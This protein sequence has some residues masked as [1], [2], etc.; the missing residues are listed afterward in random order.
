MAHCN[1]NEFASRLAECLA[2]AKGHPSKRPVVVIGSGCGNFFQQIEHRSTLRKKMPEED[3]DDLNK[4]DFKCWT[5]YENARLCSANVRP[6]EDYYV[7][8]AMTRASLVDVVITSNYDLLLDSMLQRV[9]AG[10]PFHINPI[11]RDPDPKAYNADGCFARSDTEENA[12]RIYKIHGRLDYVIFR[13]CK[14]IFRLLTFMVRY[15]DLDFL[16]RIGTDCLHYKI[17][18]ADTADLSASPLAAKPTDHFSLS[19]ICIHY[20][21][22]NFEDRQLFKPTI[23][24]AKRLLCSLSPETPILVLGFQGRWKDPALLAPGEFP[25]EDI[26][27]ELRSHIQKGGR[28]LMFLHEAQHARLANGLW[29]YVSDPGADK[30]HASYGDPSE[31]IWSAAERAGVVE[32]SD[33]KELDFEWRKRFVREKDISSFPDGDLH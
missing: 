24:A 23:D 19:G 3:R 2:E 18:S 8:H 30:C 22:F 32:Y 25:N 13:E 29:D 15:P 11:L 33:L 27:P 21:D 1:P 9:D 6:Y 12:V 28:V 5:H 20:I 7:L 26:V 31:T 10:R 14:H 17:D 16:R 4:L